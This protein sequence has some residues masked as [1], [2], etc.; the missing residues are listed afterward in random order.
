M[1]RTNY[2][3]L[4]EMELQWANAGNGSD[5]KGHGKGRPGRSRRS[6]KKRAH[7]ARLD[8]LKKLASQV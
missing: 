5:V 7:F 4:Y 1:K 8:K 2:K 6:K 3:R